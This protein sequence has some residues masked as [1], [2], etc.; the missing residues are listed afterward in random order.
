[1]SVIEELHHSLQSFSYNACI[2]PSDGSANVN[3][4]HFDLISVLV[5]AQ[6]YGV[7]FFDVSWQPALEDIGLGGTAHLS[8]RILNLRMSYVFKRSRNSPDSSG[9]QF[10]SEK[11]RVSLQAIAAEILVLTHPLVREHP[12]VIDLEGICWEIFPDNGKV[13]PVLIFERARY[14]DLRRFMNSEIGQRMDIRERLK[15]CGDIVSAVMLIHEC[16]KF[17]I[18]CENYYI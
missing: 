13:L 2:S 10:G 14:G 9:S 18:L 7:D 6:T 8:Q 16:S 15:L 11:E 5:A 12:N 3:S 4:S 17:I 1:M